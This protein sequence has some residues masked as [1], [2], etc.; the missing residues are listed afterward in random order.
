MGLLLATAAAQELPG[1]LDKLQQSRLNRLEGRLQE[2]LIDGDFKAAAEAAEEIAALRERWQGEK[3]WESADARAALQRYRAMARLPEDDRR[4]LARS[5]QATVEGTTQLRR[6]KY[7]AAEDLFREVLQLRRRVLGEDHPDTAQG[8]NYLAFVLDEQGKYADARPLFNKA[9][10]I[11]RKVLGEEHPET[12]AIYNNLAYNLT[13]QAKYADAQV[14]FEKALAIQ[15]KMLGEEHPNTIRTTNNLAVNLDEQGKYI[16]AQPL[17]EKVLAVRRRTLGDKDP[18]VASVCNN[19][20]YNLGAQGKYAQAQPLY[21]E[22]LTICRAALGEKDPATARGYNNLAANLKAQGKY[23]EAQPLYEKALAIQREVL[24]ENHPYTALTCNNLAALL[25]HQGKYAQAQPLLEKAL[26]I[27]IRVLGENHP[28]T[29]VS[30]N[31]L[32]VNLEAQAKYAQAQPLF[33]K[34]LAVTQAALGKEHSATAIAYNNLAAILQVQGKYAEAQD[35]Y[36]K[37]LAINRKALGE[38]HASTATSYNNLAGNFKEQGR[39]AEAQ[40]LYEKALAICRKALGEEH[41]DVAATCNNLAATLDAQKKYVEGQALYE[42][43]LAINRKALGEEHPDT[44]TCCKNLA[45]NAWEQNKITEAVRLLRDSLPGQEAAR[46]HHAASGFDR[47]V[48]LGKNVSPRVLLAMGLARLRQPVEAFAQAEASLARGLLDD[49]AAPA[50]ADA[51]RMAALRDQLDQLDVQLVPLLGPVRLSEEQKA[52]REELVRQ[53]RAAQSRLARLAADASA[54]LLVPLADVQQQLPADAALVLWLDVDNLGEHQACIV[55]SRGEPTWVRLN[56]SG[57]NDVW[58]DDDLDLPLRLYRTLQNPSS[59]EAERRRLSDRLSALRLRPLFPHLRGGDLPEVKHLLV[60]PTGWAGLVPLEALQ[61]GYGISYVPSAS[62]YAGLRQKHRAVEGSSLLALGDPAFAAPPSRQP[63]LVQ[64]GPDPVP[65]PGTRWEVQALARLVPRATTLLGSAASEQGLDELARAGK[66]KDY[67]LIHL[68]THGL[69]DWQTPA[70]SRLLLARD[71]LPDPKDTPPGRK[72]YTGELTVGDIRAGWQ[73]DADLVALSA[74]QTALGRQGSGEGLLG[75]AQA[76]LQCGARTVVLS[77]WP[78]DDTATALLM[79]RFYEN[80]LGARKEL[81]QPLGRAEA[82]A[83]AQ[84]WLRELP[85]RD[86]E[87]LAAALAAD[88]LSGTTRGRVVELNVKEPAA[89]LPQGEQ[90]YAHPFFWAA[91][92]LV[93]DPE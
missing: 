76:F 57:K 86:A 23:T 87:A 72:P 7:A 63:A 38:E 1:A 64:R 45:C 88:K 27:R 40:P 82:L 92:V 16:Q 59:S 17:F 65:L 10:A 22:A 33:E 11:Q 56:G 60:V 25:N 71:R 24:G 70:R 5:F 13:A 73:L 18:G 19:L 20:A 74:C 30:C 51:R 36:E 77:R 43:A 32:A 29:A 15:R 21:E 42:K 91:F 2:A 61:S 9:L 35:L 75:F 49:L 8:Y 3:H 69:V 46:F 31:N 6:H 85:R 58:T 48:A 50:A 81:K 67:R 83:E 37:A 89:K 66:L 14:F 26:A 84:R 39:H 68:A 34:A 4:Q 79:L 54:Q 41:P 52:R 90:P 55:R 80:L 47:A 12:A 53:R 62:V 44:A 78:A 28:D 93:G